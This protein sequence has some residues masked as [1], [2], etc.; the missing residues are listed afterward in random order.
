MD[1]AFL[2]DVCSWLPEY[3]ASSMSESPRSEYSAVSTTPGL[4]AFAGFISKEALFLSLH[5]ERASLQCCNSCWTRS[6]IW[7][8]KI[9]FVWDRLALSVLE[10]WELKLPS[11]IPKQ[12]PDVVPEGGFWR[13]S[14]LLCSSEEDSASLSCISAGVFKYPFIPLRIFDDPEDKW[15]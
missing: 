5:L 4:F 3:V 2:A 6:F 8:P 9:P 1:P 15:N 13:P 12:K 11:R 7:F 10:S 14:D